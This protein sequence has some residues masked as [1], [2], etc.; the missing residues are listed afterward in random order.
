MIV[1]LNL[2]LTWSHCNSLHQWDLCLSNRGY[3]GYG[4]HNEGGLFSKNCDGRHFCR[5]GEASVEVELGQLR[6]R[7]KE[8]VGDI[9]KD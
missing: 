3:W 4:F 5:F 9:D 7:H 8:L 6:I 2:I 1:F